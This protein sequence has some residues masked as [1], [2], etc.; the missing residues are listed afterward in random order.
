[1]SGEHREPGPGRSES[2]SASNRTQSHALPQIS[3]VWKS[4]LP[5]INS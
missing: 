1:M 3:E 4:K 2:V 5:E